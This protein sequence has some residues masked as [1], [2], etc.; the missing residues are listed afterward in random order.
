MSNTRNTVQRALVLDAVY[1]MRFHPS[2]D[3]IYEE[4]IK[5]HPNISKA[6]VYRNL[7]LLAENNEIRKVKIS[8]GADCFD[9]KCY[10]HYHAKCSKC[11]KVVDIEMEY[12]KDLEKQIKNTHSFNFV[13]HDITFNGICSDCKI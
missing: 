13:D 3:D 11:G 5:T 8:D 12:I 7:N 2:A 10:K 1:N 9:Y 4:I 6:T